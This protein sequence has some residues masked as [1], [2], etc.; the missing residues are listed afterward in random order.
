MNRKPLALAGALAVAATFPFAVHATNGYF[1]HG[2]GTKSKGLA[3]GG[4]AL[5]QSA[6]VAATNPA[7]MVFVGTRVDLGA[8]I[9]SPRR[10]YVA[11]PGNAMPID[12][13][14]DTEV[15]S[16][17]EWFLI[18]HFAANLMLGEDSSIGVAVYGNGGMNTTYYAKNNENN[19][20][21]FLAAN[22]TTG[23]D[24]MQLFVN[25]TYARKLNDR[26]ALGASLIAAAQRFE[27]RGF[28]FFNGFSNYDTD[29]TNKGFDYSYGGGAKVGVI[30]DLTDALSLGASYQSRIYMSEFDEYRGLFAEQGDFDIPP[31]ATIGLAF[32]PTSKTAVTFDVQRTWFSEI[33]SVGNPMANLA[34]CAKPSP[35]CLGGDQGAGFGWEDMTVYKLGFQ[36]QSSPLW[37]WR[38]GYSRTNQPITEDNVLFNVVA[39]AVME[40]HFTIG[41]TRQMGKS[42]ELSLAAF[43]AP[44]ERVRGWG[45]QAFQFFVPEKSV[46]IFMEQYEV[47]VSWAW[48]FD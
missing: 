2:Y 35:Y 21:T 43:Y 27:A 44:E 20:G 13:P 12:G 30:A 19:A 6:M 39:P 4:V 1:S 31:T 36:W 11:E 46:E 8:A 15:W 10:G 7:G 41:F 17:K 33:D 34:L 32:R 23:V 40:E 22:A 26:V 38:A 47:E 45:G 18:P 16:A 14:D 42:S 37:T 29:L 25:V 48:K 28:N 5:P 24:L 3:G 9:F